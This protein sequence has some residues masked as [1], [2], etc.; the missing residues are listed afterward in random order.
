VILQ[1]ISKIHLMSNYGVAPHDGTSR[2]IV[3]V[4]VSREPLQ[5]AHILPR[6]LRF[7]S[8]RALSLNVICI[9]E[10]ACKRVQGFE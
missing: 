3:F 8:A 7:T 5:N 4:K 6:M 2:Y 10:M 9:F 1:A